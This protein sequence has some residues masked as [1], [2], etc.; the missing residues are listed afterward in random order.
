MVRREY[1]RIRCLNRN[2]DDF[3]DRFPAIVLAAR[4]LMAQRF[5]ID[6]EAVILNKDGTPD[7]HALRGT[8]PGR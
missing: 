6:G 1:E 3:S 2:G 7:F 8:P 5:L 4:R